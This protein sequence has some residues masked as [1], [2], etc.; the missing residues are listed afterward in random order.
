[1]KIYVDADACPVVR[2][3]EETAQ[4]YSVPVVLICDTNHMLTSDYSD[5]I[6]VDKGADSADLVL[7]NL[8]SKGDIVVSQDYG[9]AAMALGKGAYPIH[10]SGRLYTDENIDELLLKRHIART[11]RRSSK[12]THLRGPRKRT[13]QDDER[14][15]Q[16][17]E[18]LIL[19]L[20]HLNRK[21]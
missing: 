17:L 16:S 12:K 19:R 11:A 9:V 18:E 20:L 3:T 2:Q 5:I 14:F 4:K 8:C 7:V 15:S 13:P 6:T 21:D 1:M 10:R